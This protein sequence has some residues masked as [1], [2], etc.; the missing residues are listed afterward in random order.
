MPCASSEAPS[1]SPE[2]CGSR[3]EPGKRR[4]STTSSIAYASSTARSSSMLRVEWPTVQIV[5][6]DTRSDVADAMNASTGRDDATS[7]RIARPRRNGLA[8][9]HGLIPAKAVG[10]SLVPRPAPLPVRVDHLERRELMS[11]VE[12]GG[13]AEKR[14]ILALGHDPKG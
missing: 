7:E 2:N 4:T 3:R 12:P 13:P 5:G 1:A 10:D 9:Q 14:G 11:V 8:L 6:V